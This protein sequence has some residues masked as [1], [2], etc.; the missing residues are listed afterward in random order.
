VDGC[1]IYR[2]HIG[3]LRGETSGKV[4]LVMTDTRVRRVVTAETREQSKVLM[5]GTAQ[6]SY[7][8]EK[9]METIQALFAD[10]LVDDDRQPV[11]TFRAMGDSWGIFAPKLVLW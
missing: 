2:N 11:V 8:Q 5:L 9:S 10:K 4:L 7:R 1:S 6:P 3:N